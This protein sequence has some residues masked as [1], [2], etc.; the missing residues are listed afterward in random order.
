V[1][2]NA[3]KRPLRVSGSHLRNQ[4]HL[5]RALFLSSILGLMA[6]GRA[7]KERSRQALAKAGGAVDY[8]KEWEALDRQFMHR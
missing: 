1:K 5:F 8:Q 6:L 4:R 2:R 7:F 3:T